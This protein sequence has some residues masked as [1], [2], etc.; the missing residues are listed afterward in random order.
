LYRKWRSQTFQELIGQEAVVR[1]LKNALQSGRVAHAYLFCGPRGTGKTS[2]ARLLAKTVNCQNPQAGEPCNACPN[3]REITENRSLDVIE[4]DAAS[5]RGIDEIRDLRDKVSVRPANSKY[6]VYVLD[7]AHMLTSEA[8]NALLKTLEEPPPYVI[9]VLATTEAH[10]MLATIVSRCQRFDFKRHTFRNTV[11][12]LHYIAGQEDVTLENGA[13]ELLA[14]AAGG[15]MRDAL[16]LLDQAIAAMGQTVTQTGV[17]Q[18]L[19]L[20]DPHAVRELVEHIA[21][22]RGADGLH[23]INT[24]AEAGADLRQLSAQVADYWRAMMLARAGADIVEI[25]DRTPEEAAE[26]RQL[27]ESFALDEL[28]ACARL[29]SQNDVGARAITI[30]QLAVELA[31]IDCLHLHRQRGDAAPAN[32]TSTAPKAPARPVP[33][34]P[35]AVHHTPAQSTTGA[36]A[37]NSSVAAPQTPKA[38]VQPI[39]ETAAPTIR[40]A[41]TSLA[42]E[43]D[44]EVEHLDLA[45]PPVQEVEAIED[46]FA[47]GAFEDDEEAGEPAAAQPG[48]T[49]E[50]VSRQ[51]EM[52]KKACKTRTPKLAALL[53]SASPVAVTGADGCEVVLQVEYDFH[54]KKLLEPESRSVVEWAFKEILQRPCRCRFL[55]KDEP[56]PLSTTPPTFSLSGQP[57]AGRAPNAAPDAQRPAEPIRPSAPDAPPRQAQSAAPASRLPDALSAQNGHGA[58]VAPG[59]TRAAQASA[60]PAN[61]LEAKVRQDPIVTE[62]IKTYGA[63]LVEWEPL[64]EDM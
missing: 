17:Q 14:R 38:T 44:D 13:A 28:S 36:P 34:S 4:I 19:G 47:P 29:F 9:F 22:L 48:L 33:A 7:E 2:A 31:F 35:P 6:K 26:I 41:A 52:V 45:A 63:K 60:P 55:Q 46:T 37:Q 30:P 61:S 12:H 58:S 51:W 50:I 23:L 54:Y 49:L 43:P 25:L 39:R 20:A 27:A 8:C 56:I 40:E 16:S 62:I 11:Q 10:R 53:N 64:K 1:T 24:L 59:K 57:G 32:P 18:M 42:Y 21:L 3:C 5:N 15:G